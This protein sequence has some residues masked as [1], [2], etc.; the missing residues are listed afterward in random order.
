MTVGLAL[1]LARSIVMVSLLFVYVVMENVG[2]L[3]TL[4]AKTVDTKKI[5]H[6]RVK[7]GIWL[8]WRT[9]M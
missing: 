2:P 6:I 4:F 8:I 3:S 5:Y 1:C 9:P 7:I